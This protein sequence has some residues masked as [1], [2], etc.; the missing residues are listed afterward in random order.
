M[1][2]EVYQAI[3]GGWS[4]GWVGGKANELVGRAS[5]GFEFNNNDFYSGKS[6]EGCYQSH[7]T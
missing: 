4:E 2:L 7:Q 5:D 1:C 3:M 6:R